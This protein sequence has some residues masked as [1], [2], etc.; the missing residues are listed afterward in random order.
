MSWAVLNAEVVK[1][2]KARIGVDDRG[3]ILGDGLFETVRA[4]NGNPFRLHDHLERL[5]NSCSV[6]NLQLP[7]GEDELSG[8]VSAL[9][10]KNWLDSA[11]VRITV[12]RGKHTGS[13]S[14][15]HAGPPTLLITAEPI[16]PATGERLEQG[17]KLKTADVR[18]SESNP[19]FK[20]KTLNRLPHLMARTYAKEQGCDEALILDEKGNVACASTGNIFALQYGQLFTPP[21]TA[22]ILPGVTRK[23]VIEIAKKES[24]PVREDFFSP[25][26]LVGADEVFITNSVQEMMS[27]IKV[28]EHQVGSGNP[29]PV[30]A[31]LLKVYR[32]LTG[33]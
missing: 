30:V 33:D 2:E 32:E 16:P 25:I 5:F 13:M 31:K 29:G 23:A 4:Y 28:N 9:I 24:I 7:W 20:H 11:R 6:F 12:T 10:E 22:P 14:L 27:V 8:M 1:T 26:M 19:V 17:I 21:L 15:N 18:F 3:P